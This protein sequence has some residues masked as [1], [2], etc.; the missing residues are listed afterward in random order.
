[1]LY[2]ICTCS[3]IVYTH[4][5]SVLSRFDSASNF[6]VVM[7][8]KFLH[9][10]FST[11]ILIFLRKGYWSQLLIFVVFSKKG[12]E[13]FLFPISLGDSPTKCNIVFQTV[14]WRILSIL[15]VGIIQFHRY[16]KNCIYCVRHSS[17]L[18]VWYMQETRVGY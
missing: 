13:C 11:D 1:M 18:G 9:P 6:T 15:I 3:G 2:V 7:T 17:V 5:V 10:M 8:Q 12:N 4:D 14:M 16:P